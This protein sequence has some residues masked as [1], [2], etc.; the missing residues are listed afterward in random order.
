MSSD[1]RGENNNIL[2][3]IDN[4]VN[5]LNVVLTPNLDCEGKLSW[6]DVDPGSTVEGSFQVFN[7]GDD[8]SLL[9]WEIESYPTDW[10]TWTFEPEFGYGLTPGGVGITV[11]VNVVAPDEQF[12][13]YNGEIKIVNI[14]DPS[15]YDTIPVILKTSKDKQLYNQQ[16]SYK[17]SQLLLE[18]AQKMII[19]YFMKMILI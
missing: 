11:N 6:S 14:D 2:D 10:G 3:I 12:T 18:C 4:V 8:F 5:N 15:D 13:N 19:N 9:N 7:I 16:K 1:V 17:S